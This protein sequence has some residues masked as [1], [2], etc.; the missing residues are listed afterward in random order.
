MACSWA[1]SLAHHRAAEVVTRGRPRW[2]V[3][4]LKHGEL[5]IAAAIAA[6]PSAS[7]CTKGWRLARTGAELAR[8]ASVTLTYSAAS[9][10]SIAS[11][12]EAGVGSRFLDRRH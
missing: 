10:Q 6:A 5:C 9:L 11:Q 8:I 7:E 4:P 3:T 2:R 1:S 12:S